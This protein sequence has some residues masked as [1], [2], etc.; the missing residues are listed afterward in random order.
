MRVSRMCARLC[1]ACSDSIARSFACSVSALKRGTTASRYSSKSASDPPLDA[2]RAANA[3]SFSLRYFI[4]NGSGAQSYCC[5]YVCR[6][7][8][9]WS[10]LREKYAGNLTHV[11]W[12]PPSSS[13]MYLNLGRSESVTL[14]ENSCDRRVTV[15]TT[16]SSSMPMLERKLMCSSRPSNE[17]CSTCGWRTIIFITPSREMPRS[18]RKS[19]RGCTWFSMENVKTAGLR[20]SILGMSASGIRS[21]F[22]KYATRGF[23]PFS[24][25]RCRIWGCLRSIVGRRSAGMPS[26]VR[27]RQR[28]TVCRLRCSKMAGSLW[29]S[30]LSS[31]PWNPSSFCKYSTRVI[32]FATGRLKISS[33]FTR[34]FSSSFVVKPSDTR[35]D[36][37]GRHFSLMCS[38]SLSFSNSASGMVS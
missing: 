35:Y 22:L 16:S 3:A 11:L 28:G 8:M 12:S 37:I 4:G 38:F 25:D 20:S 9:R 19:T 14:S 29:I 36:T 31:A 7:F 10:R 18:L 15:C 13:V 32:T 30:F 34:H 27:Y 21:S 5:R 6:G 33:Q 1:S 26:S 17:Y 24:T 2:E 23:R